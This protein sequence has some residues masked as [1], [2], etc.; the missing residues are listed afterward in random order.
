[1]YLEPRRFD[2]KFSSGCFL[3]FSI[4]LK[5]LPPLFNI[6]S[7]WLFCC[8]LHNCLFTFFWKPFLLKCNILLGLP[9]SATAPI[10]FLSTFPSMLKPL[11]KHI[12]FLTF[13]LHNVIHVQALNPHHF[14]Y[15]P[16][17]M[18]TTETSFPSYHGRAPISSSLHSA[19]NWITLNQ[20]RSM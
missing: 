10:L 16:Q 6:H 8:I 2:F 13:P 17:S 15:V 20:E 12:S 4:K 5:V 1:M 19:S 18:Q 7:P 9:P 11:M 14:S 3:K